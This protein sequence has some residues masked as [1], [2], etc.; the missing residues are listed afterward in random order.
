MAYEMILYLYISFDSC[1]CLCPIYLSH[2]LYGPEEDV[3]SL[4]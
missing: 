1:S 4:L 3:L 2:E